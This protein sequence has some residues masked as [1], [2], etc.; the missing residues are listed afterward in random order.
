MLTCSLN[1]RRLLFSLL[2][3]WIDNIGFRDEIKLCVFSHMTIP[4]QEWISKTKQI[5]I[6]TISILFDKLSGF[7][8]HTNSSFP[9]Q[10]T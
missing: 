8:Q 4:Y 5:L 1:V 10:I 6:I 7:G 3:F 2:D 9:V